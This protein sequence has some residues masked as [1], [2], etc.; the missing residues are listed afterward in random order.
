MC[1]SGVNCAELFFIFQDIIYCSSAVLQTKEVVFDF[2]II[3][4]GRFLFVYFIK[5]G[6][7]YTRCQTTKKKAE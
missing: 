1:D 3:L 5:I 7:G 4:L 2:L 6:I